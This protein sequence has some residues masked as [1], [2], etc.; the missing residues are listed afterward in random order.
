MQNVHYNNNNF[1]CMTYTRLNVIFF[2]FSLLKCNSVFQMLKQTRSNI[3]ACLQLGHEIIIWVIKWHSIIFYDWSDEC[4]HV[5]HIPR[6]HFQNNIC[7]WH[8]LFGAEWILIS[9]VSKIWFSLLYNH[10]FNRMVMCCFSRIIPAHMMPILL[11]K[12]SNNLP[13]QQDLSLIWRDDT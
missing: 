3:Y 1:V 6:K 12:I 9:S 2:Y 13:D 5:Q 8:F 10:F 7:P 11:C 4:L